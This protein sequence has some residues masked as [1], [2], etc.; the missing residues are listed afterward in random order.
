[1]SVN[2]NQSQ[3]LDIYIL[4]G[5]RTP[6]CSFMGPL[7]QVPAP[8]LGAVAIKAA[9]EQAKTN[10]P[11]LSEERVSSVIMG[12]VVQAGVGQAP[13]RQAAIGSGLKNNIPAMT[14]NKVCGSGLQAILLGQQQ[15]QTGAIEQILAGKKV[16][17]NIVVCGGMENMSL[18]PFLVPNMRSGHKFGHTQMKD[19]LMSDGL[20]DAYDQVAM[21]VCAEECVSKFKFTR[22]EQDEYAAESFRRAQKAQKEGFF[23]QEIAPVSIVTKKGTVVISE[24][25]GPAKVNFEKMKTLRPAFD[26]KG[27]ITA[28]NAS[29]INDGAAAVV[30]GIGEE[31][32]KSAKF[33]IIATAGAAHEPKWF[34]TAP[35][36]A[37]EKVLQKAKLTVDQIDLF[38]INE[39]FAVVPMVAIKEL[40][41]DDKKVNIFGGGISLGHP[42]GCSGTRIIVTLMTA[43][44]H[45]QAKYGLA[46]ICIGGGEALSIIVER[47]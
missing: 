14:V 12:N 34:T 16:E 22:E 41:L 4:G 43:L 45:K 19:S 25:D 46:A 6:S 39:A 11:H 26:P 24:D 15:L 9:L 36:E 30:L 18:A 3:Q 47:M 35:V 28:A 10:H 40:G 17:E 8:Q 23:K 31:F 7:D 29:T 42:I 44:E 1:M 20:T 33:K 37:I 21:G 27:T 5:A 32:K 38:E 2:L 13:A